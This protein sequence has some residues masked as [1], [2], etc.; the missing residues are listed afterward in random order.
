MVAVGWYN[1]TQLSTD[2][3]LLALVVEAGMFHYD[4]LFCF[5][6]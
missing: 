4:D 3:R 1:V 5:G 6:D 2:S